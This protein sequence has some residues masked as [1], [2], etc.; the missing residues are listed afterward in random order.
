LALVELRE[1]N[2]TNIHFKLGMLI[3]RLTF[4]TSGKYLAPPTGSYEKEPDETLIMPK[5]THI[6]KIQF[7]MHKLTP[8][9]WAL[10]SLEIF[11]R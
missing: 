8:S 9:N 6:K 3:T 4:E 2:Y 7:G 11:N 1:T 10:C 5:N